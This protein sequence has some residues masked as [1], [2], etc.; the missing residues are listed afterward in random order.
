MITDVRLAQIAK[1]IVEQHKWLV[2][3][4]WDT[5]KDE[6]DHSQDRALLGIAETLLNEAHRLIK[7]VSEE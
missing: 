2:Q 1:N 6:A 4:T 5:F 7:M 3:V